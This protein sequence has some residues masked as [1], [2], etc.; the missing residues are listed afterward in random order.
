DRM[1]LC[2]V[3]YH[4]VLASRLVCRCGDAETPQLQVSP[5]G[6]AARPFVTHMNAFY[7]YLYLRIAPEL[8]LKRAAA[9]G[10]EKVYEINRNLR[11][12]GAGST[13]SPEFAMREAY[14]ASGEYDTS[15]DLSQRLVQE[16]A[17]QAFGSRSVAIA[18]G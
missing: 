12:E 11:N 13:H 4:S 17:G 7:L 16:A 15:G 1:Q 14:E 5:A 6:A 3:R 10:L 8:F 9:G 2:V 18:A